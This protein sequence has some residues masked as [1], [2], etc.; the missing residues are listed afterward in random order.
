MKHFDHGFQLDV[1]NW[2]GMGELCEDACGE[3]CEG[4]LEYGADHQNQEHCERTSFHGY[5]DVGD[6][7]S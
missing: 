4:F 1:S 5:I 6:I 2:D 7:I 3:P